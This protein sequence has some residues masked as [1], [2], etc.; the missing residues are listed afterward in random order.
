M[1]E[2]TTPWKNGYYYN[3]NFTP[4]LLKVTGT[5]VD[6]FN[7]VYL[8]HPDMAPRAQGTWSFGDYGSARQEIIDAS[9][10]HTSVS[11]Y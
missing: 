1:S 8:D 5:R 7:M 10:G 2:Q 9:G 6:F 4:E 3:E 11:T